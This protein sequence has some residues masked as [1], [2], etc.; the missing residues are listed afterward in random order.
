[1]ADAY[2]ERHLAFP[3]RDDAGLAIAVVDISIKGIKK[4]PGMENREVQR[5][6]KL[7]QMAHKEITK[8]FAGEDRHMVLGRVMSHVSL[9][10][11][12]V[13]E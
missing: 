1:M 8:E 6:L 5:M 2:G 12:D 11:G 7:L 4:L 13:G 9:Y 10:V 3:L